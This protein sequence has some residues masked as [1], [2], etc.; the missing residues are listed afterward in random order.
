MPRKL[1]LLLLVTFLS[2]TFMMAQDAVVK[3]H[4]EPEEAFIFVD[5]QP[6]GEGMHTLTLSPGHHTIGVYNYGFKPMVKE[7]TL[8]AGNGNEDLRFYLEAAGGPVSGPWGVIQIEG[9]ERAAVLLNGKEPEYFVGHGDEFNNHIW[10][11]QQLIVPVGTHYLTVN[12]KGH[13]IWSGKVDVAANKRVIIDFNHNAQMTVKD[14]VEGGRMNSLPRFQGGTASATVAVAA[15]TATFTATPRQINCNDKVNLA[16]NTTETLH[17]AIKSTEENFPELPMNGRETV[18]PKH[19]TT[20][21][22]KTSGPGGIVESA[23]TVDVNPAVK[24]DLATSPEDV[25]Y[26]RIGDKVITQDHATLTWNVVN[27]DNVTLEPFGK[28]SA[29]GTNTVNPAPNGNAT[30]T[31]NETRSYKLQASNVC[32]GSDEKIATVHLVGN[33]EPAIASLFFPTGYPDRGHPTKGL[34][35]SQQARLTTIAT[36]FKLYL[37]HEPDAKLQLV[38]YADPRG[39]RKANQKLSARRAMIVKDFLVAQGIP[40]DHIMLQIKGEKS[41]LDRSTVKMLEAQNPEPAPAARAKRAR[42]TRLAYDRRVDVEIQPIAT[43]SVR[44]FPHTADDSALL[45][46]PRWL[47]QSKIHKASQ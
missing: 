35:K 38:G 34:L 22:F 24:A 1:G 33:V 41:P 8:A 23:E 10:W 31:I 39:H 44:F 11:K 43:E 30:G 12:N 17:T 29:T 6:V 36:V 16:W 21:N 15:V 4:V 40:A 25:H 28:V 7:V 2:A 42:A 9:A 5:A 18:S 20:Y 13:E 47:G 32:G 37:E 14:W 19:T 46:N 45:F 27:A 3:V 26:L